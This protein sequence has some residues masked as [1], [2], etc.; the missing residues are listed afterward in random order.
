MRK[1]VSIYLFVNP[2]N[3][4]ALPSDAAHA[5]SDKSE[6]VVE[7]EEE[8]EVKDEEQRRIAEMGRP[9]LG[10]HVKMEIII[11]ESYEFKVGLLFYY[12]T[13]YIY[14]LYIYHNYMHY[15]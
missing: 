11:E 15:Y 5:R 2:F 8:E 4:N 13:V 14:I 10:E 12:Y 6:K 7:E 9:M 1:A 3:S